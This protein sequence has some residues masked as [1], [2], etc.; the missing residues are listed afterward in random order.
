MILSG[1]KLE[2]FDESDECEPEEPLQKESH[3]N[4]Q[5]EKQCFFFSKNKK[6]DILFAETPLEFAQWFEH[7]KKC[8][9]SLKIKKKKK[10]N[11]P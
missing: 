8:I 6:F 4:I 3:G 11:F 9:K 5:L 2:I 10:M 7:L 1:M